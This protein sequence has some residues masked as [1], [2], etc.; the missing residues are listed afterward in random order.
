LRKLRKN[1]NRWYWLRRSKQT[2]RAGFFVVARMAWMRARLAAPAPA[3]MRVLI[4]LTV[5]IGFA[6]GHGTHFLWHICAGL[7]IHLVLRGLS[8]NLTANA[9]H[10]ATRP[11]VNDSRGSGR[12]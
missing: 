3:S 1:P 8:A 6:R 5:A 9:H 12:D 4:A 11:S 2:S 7:V 10:A